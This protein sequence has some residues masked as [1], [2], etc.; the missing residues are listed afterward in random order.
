MESQLET[1]ALFALKLVYETEGQ[2]PV[3]RDDLIMSDYQKDVFGLLIR[4][5][6]VA[7]IQRKV[8]ECL[9]LALTALGGVETP[10]GREL[11]KLSANVAAAQT[12]EQLAQ[13]LIALKDYLKDVQ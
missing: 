8:D 13:P 11:H 2:S 7:T 1:V 12:L 9:S 10:L 3:L 4:R 6:D 5:G